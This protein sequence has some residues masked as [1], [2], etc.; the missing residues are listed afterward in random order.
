MNKLQIVHFFAKKHSILYTS[1]EYFQDTTEMEHKHILQFLCSA[2]TSFRNLHSSKICTPLQKKCTNLEL[3]FIFFDSKI[4][5]LFKRSVQ[6]WSLY[7][8]FAAPNLY[9]SLQRG[10]QFWSLTVLYYLSKNKLPKF[11][12]KFLKKCTN[13]ELSLCET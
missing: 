2:L 13:L 5:H 10:V 8:F 3:I 12:H 7:L 11:V 9:I 1:L 6:F 4:V